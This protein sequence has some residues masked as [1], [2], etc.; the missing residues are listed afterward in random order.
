VG[1]VRTVAREVSNEGVIEG[2]GGGEAAL[3]E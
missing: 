1:V 2:E 3:D